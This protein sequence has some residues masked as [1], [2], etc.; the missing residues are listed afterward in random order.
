[1]ICFPTYY[2]L[3]YVYL[4]I[5]STDNTLPSLYPIPTPTSGSPLLVLVL[6]YRLSMCRLTRVTHSMVMRPVLM[7]WDTF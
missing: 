6:T 5:A 4:Y 3:Q 1:M 2:R 7:I